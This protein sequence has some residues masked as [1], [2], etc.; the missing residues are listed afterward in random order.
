M[1]HNPDIFYRSSCHDM[2][3]EDYLLLGGGCDIN[4]AIYGEKDFGM[5]QSPNTHRDHANIQ[6]I[7]DYVAMGK[8]IFGIC[9]GFQL[10]DAV[11]G[12]KLIQ[13]TTGHPNGV[14]VNTADIPDVI[15]GNKIDACR[16][17]HH[18]VVDVDHTKGT[19]IGWA[20]YPM[21]AYFGLGSGEWEVRNMVPE[22]MYWP[23][24]KALAVQFHPEWQGS[25][26]KMNI[27]LR[28]LI[29]ELL[30]LENVL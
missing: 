23:E 7:N 30:G 20:N 9:R 5:S 1:K 12:G 16:N 25:N 14:T 22:I 21:R 13:H 10:L 2:P 19:I 29:K 11:F 3:F 28:G 6:A 24:K 8:P 18:Q 17:C 27:H 4:P 26:H 15:S